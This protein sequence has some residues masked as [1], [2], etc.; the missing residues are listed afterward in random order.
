L[1]FSRNSQGSKQNVNLEWKFKQ[2][3]CNFFQFI[4]QPIRIEQGSRSR[5][6]GPIKKFPA[7]LSSSP[8]F[9]YLSLQSWIS[10]FWI[11]L[12]FMCFHLQQNSSPF[13]A[14]ASTSFGHVVSELSKAEGWIAP[15]ANL[16]IFRVNFWPIYSLKRGYFFQAKFEPLWIIFGPILNEWGQFIQRNGH[17]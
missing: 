8:Y 4:R 1:F 15:P 16:E 6:W 13:S 10:S 7:L 2:K 12:S 11:E 5:N 9:S 17:F 3:R 14:A